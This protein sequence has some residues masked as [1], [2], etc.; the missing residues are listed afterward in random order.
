VRLVF[1]IGDGFEELGVPPGPSDIFGWATLRGQTKLRGGA[2]S[3]EH[4]GPIPVDISRG[5]RPDGN[6]RQRLTSRLYA[7]GWNVNPGY[8]STSRRYQQLTRVIQVMA[9]N[10]VRR[11]CG[12][13]LPPV[14]T[15]MNPISNPIH[16]MMAT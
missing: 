12:F 1:G 9:L 10:T 11:H 15:L 16:N 6:S 5:P 3:S 4:G 13:H 7:Y 2:T 8:S 14:N